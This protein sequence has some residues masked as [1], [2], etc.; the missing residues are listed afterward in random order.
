MHGHSRLSDIAPRPLLVWPRLFSG[1]RTKAGYYLD[2]LNFPARVTIMYLTV[3][4]S[5]TSISEV[6]VGV[7]GPKHSQLGNVYDLEPYVK[8]LAG[9]PV[10]IGPLPG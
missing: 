6:T 5:G 8:A 4:V 7:A 9:T 10:R 2:Y 3:S 1:S